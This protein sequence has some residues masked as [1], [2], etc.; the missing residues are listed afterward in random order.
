[1]FIKMGFFQVMETGKAPTRAVNYIRT[2]TKK[3]GG[4]PNTLVE[5][6]VVCFKTLFVNFYIYD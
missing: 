4:Y 5:E 3:G 6:R 2:H 1:M